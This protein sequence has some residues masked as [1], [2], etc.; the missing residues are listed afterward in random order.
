MINE[1]GAVLCRDRI[2]NDCDGLTDCAEAGCNLLSCNPDGG[3]G[4]ECAF[5]VRTETDCADRRDNDDDG[6]TDCG[7]AL[8]DGGGDCP[9]NTPCTFL[10]NGLVK[11]G[12]CASDRT[13]R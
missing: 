8:P 4:C 2:D 12:A 3:P 9:V 7:D 5:G 11:V 1:T 10:F 6:T 13:C